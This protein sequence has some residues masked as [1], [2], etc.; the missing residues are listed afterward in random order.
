MEFQH[1]LN[2]A[3]ASG[4][5]DI[6]LKPGRRPVLRVDGE[7][8]PIG[9]GDDILSVRD[10]DTAIKGL[11]EEEAARTLDQDLEHDMGREMTSG[12]K[13]VRLR[14]NI[15]RQQTGWGMVMRILPD[16]IPGFEAI[17]LEKPI[18]ELASMPRGLVLVTGPT[19]SG[20]STTLASLLDAVNRERSRHIYTI[21]DPI[22]YVYRAGRS[23]VTQRELH[24]HT[25]SFAGALRSAM[26]ADPDVIL[27]GEMRDLETIRLALTAAET[28]HLVLSTL[29]TCDTTQTIDR[30]VDVFPGEQQGMVRSQLA[31]VLQAVISQV[32]LPLSEGPGRIAAREILLA[33]PAVRNLIRES[34]THQLY[35]TLCS[36]V[37]AGM[38]PLEL[39]LAGLVR[40]RQI[41]AENARAVVNRLTVFQSYLDSANL[42]GN[43]R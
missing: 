24:T 41:D 11:L 38:C 37:A 4:A 31:N 8:R 43:F 28:G 12:D 13:R 5:S 16:R 19:G 35:S 36:S 21:E 42:P 32:L 25:R 1:I 15:H 40:D 29:H 22:E 18:R 17:T 39:S 34:K 30:I 14:I 7:M 33:S 2:Q 3:I 20:K 26:R 9:S 27:V 10:L 23:E 6:H